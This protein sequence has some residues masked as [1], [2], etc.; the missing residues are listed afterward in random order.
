MNWKERMLTAL[1]GGRPDRVPWFPRMQLWYGA[2]KKMETLP[3]RYQNWSLEDIYRDLG[4]GIHGPS[5]VCKE[6]Y[7]QMEIRKKKSQSGEIV[8]YETPHGDLQCTFQAS[9]EMQ[10][11]DIAPYLV[12]PPVKSADDFD[13]LLYLLDH[14]ELAED[15]AAFEA[16][17]DRIGNDGVAIAHIGASP[18]Q[19]FLREYMGFEKGFLALYDYPD[20]VGEIINKFSDIFFQMIRIV[21][22]SPAVIIKLQDNLTALFQSPGIFSKYYLPVYRKTGE[23]LHNKGKI[24]TVHGDGE[25]KPL[26]PLLIDSGIDAVEQFTPHPMTRCT[27]KEALATARGHYA[28]WGGIPSTHLCDPVSEN[29]FQEFLDTLFQAL[30]PEDRFILSIGDNVMP[31]AHL[32]RIREI[33]RRVLDA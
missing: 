31:E 16:D 12:E 5:Q 9:T 33:T 19:R 32:G 13:S 11:R 24:L 17:A 2:H 23:I 29:E 21:A 30:T 25:M 18:C 3:K 4:V 28:V 8:V 1:S 27:V 6:R 14:I 20:R 7:T 22:D 10:R 15:Y 26:L